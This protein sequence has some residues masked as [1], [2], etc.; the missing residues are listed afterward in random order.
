M[1][2]IKTFSKLMIK[3]DHVTSNLEEIE[4]LNKLPKDFNKHVDDNFKALIENTI[5]SLKSIKKNLEDYASNKTQTSE[6][7]EDQWESHLRSLPSS[8]SQSNL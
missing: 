7:F 1:S 6:N 3:V 5:L 2:Q 4:F 8:Y